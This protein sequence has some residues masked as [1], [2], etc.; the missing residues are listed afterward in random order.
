MATSS[1]QELV[2]PAAQALELAAAVKVPCNCFLTPLAALYLKD[3]ACVWLPQSPDGKFILED[4]KLVSW[5]PHPKRISTL[6]LLEVYE[7]TEI[8]SDRSA[9]QT[10]LNT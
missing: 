7:A 9:V 1:A 3:N 8:K 2:Q 4:D 5:C 6:C 10:C